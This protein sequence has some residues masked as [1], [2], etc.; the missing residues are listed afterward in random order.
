MLDYNVLL[1]IADSYKIKEFDN[2]IYFVNE[3]EEN[4]LKKYKNK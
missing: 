2:L 3:I 4:L 1:R